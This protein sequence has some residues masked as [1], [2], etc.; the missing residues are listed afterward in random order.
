MEYFKKLVA[1]SISDSAPFNS[2]KILELLEY[3][4]KTNR[5]DIS[6]PCF[7]LSKKL[8]PG[9][10]AINLRGLSVDFASWCSYKYLNSGPG[11]IS[12]VYINSKHLNKNQ[13][14]SVKT[15]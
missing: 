2:D 12:G 9:N 3:P 13:R 14:R 8:N 10:V 7:T 6:L 5:G 15:K 1:K 11:G 4:D